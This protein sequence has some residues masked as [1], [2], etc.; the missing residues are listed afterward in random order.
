MPRPSHLD[1]QPP[2]ATEVPTLP[3]QAL[4]ER[5]QVSLADLC[6]LWVFTGV[7][8]RHEDHPPFEGPEGSPVDAC[9]A[10]EKV[11]PACPGEAPYPLS[12][13]SA[14]TLTRTEPVL[15]SGV[16]EGESRYRSPNRGGDVAKALM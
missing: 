6:V 14:T 3:L 10:S 2:E 12:D 11:H 8:Q 13:A 4:T 1:T 5:F 9:E 15:G 7:G 16:L